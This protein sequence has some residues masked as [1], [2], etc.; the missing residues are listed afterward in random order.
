V[1]SGSI[2][3][4][5]LPQPNLVI[6]AAG[7]AGSPVYPP[8]AIRFD[9]IQVETLPAIVPA[10]GTFLLILAGLFSGL[11]VARKIRA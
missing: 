4:S 8:Y 9:N 6:G 3:V 10:P 11:G 2:A 1:T 5:V 7:G